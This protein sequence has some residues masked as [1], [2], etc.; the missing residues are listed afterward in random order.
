MTLYT[1]AGRVV[2]DTPIRGV[3]VEAAQIMLEKPSRFERVPTHR[4]QDQLDEWVQN[5]HYWF[6]LAETYA[7]AN[8]WPMNDTACGNYG[9]CKFREVCGKSPQVREIYLKSDFIQLKEEDRWNPLKP[10]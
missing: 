8:Y 7:E 1:L 2:L 3:I 5:L 4:T 6:N 9:G 10:R